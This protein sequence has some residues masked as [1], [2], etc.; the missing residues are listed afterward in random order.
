MLIVRFAIAI[1]G[2]M[3]IRLLASCYVCD[4]VIN[5]YAAYKLQIV[6]LWKTLAGLLLPDPAPD[7]RVSSSLPLQ[8]TACTS[9][10][11]SGIMIYISLIYTCMPIYRIAGNFRGGKI[12]VIF[13][14]ERGKT[15]I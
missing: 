5:F 10:M 9:G 3:Q 4:D 8:Y 7:H 14:P 15:K 2:H 11:I 1:N 6:C 12:L 13:V